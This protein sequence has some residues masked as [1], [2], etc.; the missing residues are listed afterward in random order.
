LGFPVMGRGALHVRALASYEASQRTEALLSAY[1][2]R[3]P[4]AGETRYS[5]TPGGNVGELGSG[6]VLGDVQ[7][8][9]SVRHVSWM[10]EGDAEDVDW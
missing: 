7:F 5:P 9:P 10:E 6:D 3:V 8:V 2:R 1:A 4:G